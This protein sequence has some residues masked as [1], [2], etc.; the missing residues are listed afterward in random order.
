MWKPSGDRTDRSHERVGPQRRRVMENSAPFGEV[1][2]AVGKLSLD[3]Q[4]TLLAIVRHRLAEQARKRVAQDIQEA[5]E[6]F[7]QG[8]CEP[9]TVGDLM[10]EIRS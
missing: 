2:E 9:T 10:K 5:R 7:A 4:E 3:E 8:R 6:E 1:L